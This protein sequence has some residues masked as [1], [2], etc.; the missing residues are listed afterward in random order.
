MLSKFDIISWM[1]TKLSFSQFIFERI[2]GKRHFSWYNKTFGNRCPS[3]V[4]IDNCVL[5]LKREESGI[6]DEPCSWKTKFCNHS[7]KHLLGLWFLADR[8]TEHT[9]ILD[10]LYI[11]WNRVFHITHQDLG[12]RKLTIKWI[13]KCLSGDRERF[14]VTTSRKISLDSYFPQSKNFPVQTSASNP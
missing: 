10:A 14:R 6:E 3:Y 5:G 8:Q 12:M 9:R 2:I 13:Q 7:G 1:V 4:T 11:S